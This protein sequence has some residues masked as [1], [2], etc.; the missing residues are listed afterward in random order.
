VAVAHSR[1]GAS[2]TESSAGR[3]TATAVGANRG[4]PR[5]RLARRWPG[6]DLGRRRPSSTPRALAKPRSRVISCFASST[7]EDEIGV[8]QG[9]DV[10][11]GVVARSRNGRLERGAIATESTG[12]PQ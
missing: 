12:S 8:R 2:T 9:R 11:P 5:P 10:L 1:G 4:P 7:R 3:A 6:R